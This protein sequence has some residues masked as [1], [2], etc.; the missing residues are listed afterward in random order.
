MNPQRRE[1]DDRFLVP[2]KVAADN[3]ADHDGF[4]D[5]HGIHERDA[6]LLGIQP[7]DRPGF[8]GYEG[9]LTLMLG[10]SRVVCMG[11]EGDEGVELRG[12]RVGCL[13]RPRYVA[14]GDL[15]RVFQ[16]GV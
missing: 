14:F 12:P 11:C 13:V 6:A 3:R 10:S 1:G 2:A 16:R 5:R 9:G 7:S 4:L 15:W 8:I